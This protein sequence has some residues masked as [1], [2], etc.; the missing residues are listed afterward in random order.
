MDKIRYTIRKVVMENEYVV[1]FTHIRPF[2]LDS[3]YVTPL[4]TA[5][6]DTDETVAEMIM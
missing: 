2:Y 1:N 5:V 4:S 3:V 6:K